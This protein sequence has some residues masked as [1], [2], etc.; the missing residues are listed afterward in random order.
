MTTKLAIEP[1]ELLRTLGDRYRHVEQDHQ[2]QPPR[3]ATRHRIEAEMHNIHDQFERLLAEWVGTDELRTR[4]REFLQGRAAPPD[5]PRLP[6]PPLFKGRTDAGAVVEVRP[7]PDGYDVISDGVRL[8][9]NNVPWVLEPDMRGPVRIGDQTCDEV[10]DAPDDAVRALAEFLA[11]HAA[12]PWRWARELVEDGLID[13][14]FALT[15]RGERCL[16]RLRPES[17]PVARARSVCV[18]VADA[19]RARLWILEAERAGMGPAT[20][21]LVD[22]AETTNPALRARDVDVLSDDAGRR[23][24]NKTPIHNPPDHRDHRRRDVERH[25]AARIAE[26]AAAV[27]RRYGATELI[28]AAGPVMLGLLRSALDRQLQ[29]KE[30]LRVREVPRDLTKLTGPA[31]HDALAKDKLLPER[32]RR[33]PVIPSPGLPT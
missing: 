33:A 15:P 14:E 6:A 7:V 21:E 27:W 9:H 8:D 3:G 10:F 1:I 29:A 16:A 5:A 4:W 17:V 22:V 31:L 23:G 30:D 2:R 12:P 19:V 13:T 26:E 32:G 24:G 11:G 20:F 28:V 18:L 25:F